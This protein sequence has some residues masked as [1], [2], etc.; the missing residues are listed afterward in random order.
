M[1]LFHSLYP[2]QS[3][4]NWEW[5]TAVGSCQTPP[6]LNRQEKKYSKMHPHRWIQLFSLASED[7]SESQ[8]GISTLVLKYIHTHQLRWGYFKQKLFSFHRA[9]FKYFVI[10]L[11]LGE[12]KRE[13]QY[14]CHLSQ[15]RIISSALTQ[16]HLDPLQGLKALLFI[17]SSGKGFSF[18]L[19]LTPTYFKDLPSTNITHLSCCD[20]NT[21]PMEEECFPRSIPAL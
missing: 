21:T 13:K 10:L 12:H 6:S 18:S 11:C 16:L 14:F 2:S 9:I 20:S 19:K 15:S 5:H 7:I 17:C 4:L 1:S 3:H 8:Q